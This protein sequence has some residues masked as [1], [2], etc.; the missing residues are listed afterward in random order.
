MR[1]HEVPDLNQEAGNN[2]IQNLAETEQTMAD[3]GLALRAYWETL[4]PKIAAVLETRYAAAH[5]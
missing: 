5:A 3:A 4:P 2:V 1:E